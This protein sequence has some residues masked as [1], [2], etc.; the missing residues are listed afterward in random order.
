MWNR[1]L[2]KEIYNIA[3]PSILSNLTVPL[4]GIFDLVIVGHL[5]ASSYIGG[6]AVAST[7][8]SMLYWVFAFLRMGTT[9]L[10]AQ[11]Y[12]AA[13]CEEMNY[14]LLR[15]CLVSAMISIV[16]LLLQRPIAE[17]A[18]LI[19][20]AT[21]DVRTH[22]YTYYN[23]CIWGAPA[24]LAQY[25]LTGWFLGMQ[26]AK[27]PLSVSI[28]Q[29]V[30]NVMASFCFVY[31]FDMN[32][33]G[34]AMGTLLAQYVGLFLSLYFCK[35]TYIKERLEFVLNRVKL[36]DK[37]ILIRFFNVNKDIFLRTLCLV[38]VTLYFTSAGSRQGEVILAVNAL[39]M[40]FFLLYSYFMD[41][42]AFAGEALSG[43]YLGARKYTELMQTLRA[44]FVWGVAFALFATLVYVGGGKMFVSLMTDQE[45]VVMASATYMPWVYVIPVAGMAAFIWD[46]VFIGIT[47][48]RQ[49]LISMAL[50]MVLF[51]VVEVSLSEMMR[52]HA[53]WL[54][55]VVYIS[56]RGIAQSFLFFQIKR[57]W[58]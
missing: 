40:Q 20:D 16:L 29:N 47:A 6:I 38:C 45:N 30:V 36:L 3:L 12:G 49:M 34:V 43:R 31:F 24:V 51:F 22:A 25:S 35:S 50:S 1:K 57:R 41:G 19:V 37:S 8:F 44:L 13:D 48:T 54:A 4:L 52:N 39:L 23:I 32:I 9:G 7:I 42:V 55:F 10:T 56:M 14:C 28:V 26:N 21:L 58:L 18:F 15:S 53:L 17:F 46:G 2:H 33:A 11:S 5:G 27:A